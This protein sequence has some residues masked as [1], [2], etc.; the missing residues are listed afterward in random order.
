MH[1]A[2]QARFLVRPLSGIGTVTYA[3]LEALGK[4]DHE[5]T[6]TILTPA[7]PTAP[8]ALPKNFHIKILPEFL[9][10]K[11]WQKP[12][13]GIRKTYWERIQVPRAAQKIKADFLH[14]L[15]PTPLHTKLPTIITV[16]DCIPWNDKRYQKNFLSRLYQKAAQKSVHNATQIVAVSQT[17]QHDLENAGIS[18]KKITVILNGP[19]RWVHQKG[20][21]S[22][23]KMPYL[24][25][26]GGF[27]PRKNVATLISIFTQKIAPHYPVQLIIAGGRT[28]GSTLDAE[29]KRFGLQMTFNGD[30]MQESRQRD[31]CIFTG[32]VSDTQLAGLLHGCLAFVHLSEAEGFN[33][34]LL[35]AA[36]L[37]KPI[38][39]SDIPAH[40]ELLRQSPEARFVPP[41]DEKAIAHALTDAVLGKLQPV[42]PPQG[43]TWH[44][45]AEKTLK[46][47]THAHSVLDHSRH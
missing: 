17:T 18:S 6:Y 8:L 10:L 45:A 47:Y 4:I 40:R 23:L 21:P 32:T 3:L 5:N 44:A 16:H 22:D 2:I 36:M 29:Y 14:V 38:I 31:R 46:L 7:A 30:T 9:H 37:R 13:A 25:Y 33:I 24:L 42:T 20:T 19:D 41:H 34:P 28:H 1:I 39:A 35:S 43:Y 11:P 12:F 15:Y 27:D 26:C